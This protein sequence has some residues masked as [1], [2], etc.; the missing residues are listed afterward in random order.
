MPTHTFRSS[1]IVDSKREMDQRRY[2][3]ERTCDAKVSH[4]KSNC[5]IV[6]LF[7]LTLTQLAMWWWWW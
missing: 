6:A 5:S 4:A 3:K 7:V 1:L 2:E